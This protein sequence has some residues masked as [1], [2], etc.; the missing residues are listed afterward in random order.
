MDTMVMLCVVLAF[1]SVSL[2]ARWC[3]RSAVRT[4]TCARNLE[5]HRAAGFRAVGVRA[6]RLRAIGLRVGGYGSRLTRRNEPETHQYHSVSQHLPYWSTISLYMGVYC[7]IYI[8]QPPRILYFLKSSWWTMS[9]SGKQMHMV[10][11]HQKSHP[12]YSFHFQPNIMAF[13]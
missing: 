3:R 7:T 5:G 10:A 6:V 4:R 12:K 2:S 11:A 8:T 13:H 1:L 9:G